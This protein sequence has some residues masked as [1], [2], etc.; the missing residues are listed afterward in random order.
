M[1]IEKKIYDFFALIVIHKQQ[2]LVDAIKDNDE[3][4]CAKRINV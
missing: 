3:L 1:T 4:N 2:H